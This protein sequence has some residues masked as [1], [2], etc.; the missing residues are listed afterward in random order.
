MDGLLL[1]QRD[2]ENSPMPHT[3]V[4][5]RTA[6]ILHGFCVQFVLCSSSKFRFRS[7]SE[8]KEVVKFQENR[9]FNGGRDRD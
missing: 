6:R 8:R 2:F 1:S 5:L 9:W 4:S 3:T 7:F